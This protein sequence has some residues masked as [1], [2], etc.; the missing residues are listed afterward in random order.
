MSHGAIVGRPSITST[1]KDQLMRKSTTLTPQQPRPGWLS[2]QAWPHPIQTI[3]A[4]DANIA[5]TDIGDG[6]TLLLVHVGMWSILWRDIIGQL[7]GTYRCVTL[8]SPGCGFSD[9][10]APR[11][12]L[13][14]AANAVDAIVCELDLT[15]IT[16]VMHDLGAPA[17]LEAAARWPERVAALCVI[18]GFGWRPSG[19]L[20]RGML[21][22]M[23]N[24]A[25]G[26]IDA[27]TGWLPRAS[28][29]RFG[30]GRRWDRA[31]RKTYRSGIRRPQR[32]S[33]HCYMNAARRHDYT[34]ID[35]T[36]RTLAHDLYSPSSGN[37][38]TRCAS[39]P[40]GRPASP[41][42]IRSPSRRA[43]TSPCATTPTSS[44]AP[45]T[46]GTENTSPSLADRASLGL[47]IRRE[48]REPLGG[49]QTPDL[50]EHAI[51]CRVGRVGAHERGGVVK[52]LHLTG[53]SLAACR[54]GREQQALRVDAAGGDCCGDSSRTVTCSVWFN[55]PAV[56]LH[57]I[58]D[59]GSR[60][61]Q[62]FAVGGR[63]RLRDRGRLLG[64]EVKHFAEDVGHAMIAVET[65][66]HAERATEFD[67][68]DDQRP[69]GI[70]RSIRKAAGQLLGEHVER[71]LFVLDARPA[72]V[73]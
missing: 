66:Q 11:L 57:E 26:E 63:R 59:A 10:P 35:Q 65:L 16:L 52:F 43:T 56:C 2:L 69:G 7:G 24:P 27:V 18:N 15:N 62:P 3:S 42:P 37:A 12:T 45:S 71:E 25:I 46:T 44:P 1:A 72:S 17:A 61:R 36:V 41:M 32:R 70:S 38:T 54:V 40:N 34:R 14:H 53:R 23:G 50:A 31:T 58:T 9:R 19:P 64:I 28:A 30:V 8:D 21:A 33:L 6:P 67:L 20:F 5:Y 22:T 73:E 29:T 48:Q 60:P 39:N 51:G 47:V 49:E 4:N 55:E 68:L 13:T